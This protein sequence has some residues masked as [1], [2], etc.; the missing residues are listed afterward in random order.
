MES[1]PL[2]WFYQWFDTWP[3]VLVCIH[4]HK[5]ISQNA[6]LSYIAF[7]NRERESA[8]NSPEFFHASIL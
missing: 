7:D 5:R 4:L 8:F 3:A 1:D 2:I 6:F